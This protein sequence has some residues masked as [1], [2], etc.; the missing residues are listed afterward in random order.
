MLGSIY[1]GMS[2]M[3][4]YS[5][6]LQTISNNVANL[7]TTGFKANSVSFADVAS[8]GGSGLQFSGGL[9]SNSGEGVTT[10]PELIDFSQGDLRQTGNDLD[11]AIKGNGFLVLEK[12]DS[13]YYARTG[14]FE[15]D[16]DGYI[17]QQGTGYHLG[18]IDAN[19]R[20]EPVNID[21][22]RTSSPEATTKI[23]FADNLSSSATEASVA[24]IAVFDSRGGKQVWT[25]K[26][27]KST[28]PALTNA[29]NVT[30]SDATGRQ[31][32]TSV[33]KFL[34]SVVDPTTSTLTISDTPQGADPLSVTLD[35]SSGIT[36]F[37]SGTTSTLRAANVDGRG[38][39]ALATASVD[40]AGKI[41]LTY[42]N[43]ET[44][45][46]GAVAIADFRDPQQ[47]ERFGEGL[48]RSRG[49]TGQMRILPSGID[50]IGTLVSKQIEASNVNLSDEFGELILI[51][52]GFQASSQVV[53]ISND[54]IQQLFGIKGQ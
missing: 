7:N 49:G 10:G 35:F 53:S 48:Y 30:V 47:L 33:L 31:V 41:K 8:E 11:L 5:K 4:A 44:E 32:G 1:I 25:V 3:N 52:R 2:G 45:L 28:D 43:G 50:G 18:V 13:V 14:Q 6:G 27:T 24:D 15:I 42:S 36:S 12:D 51:Q 39:G 34:G 20:A 38:V 46:L 40:E 23:V 19:G 22:K 37:S 21:S 16:K 26:F 17:S 29:W 9:G 54:M